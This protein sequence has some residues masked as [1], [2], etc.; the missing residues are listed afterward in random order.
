M[1]ELTKQDLYD[2]LYGCTILGTGGGGELKNG[3]RLIDKAFEDGKKF[4]LADL[5]ELEDE[6]LIATPYMCGAI[7]PI[8]EEEE[9]KYSEL[10]QIG[11]EPAVHAFIAMEEY[12]GEKFHGVVSTELGGS[13]T[14]VAFYTAAMLGKYI[15][16]ADPAGR[17]VPEL[18]HSTYYI[19]NLPIHP[20]AVANEFGD[21]A[22][23][24]K[25]VNDFRAEALV[26]SLAVVSKNS[27]G[28]VDHPAKAADLKNAV[29][30]KAISYALK[31]GK[32]H[33]MA[34]ENNEDPA[35][36]VAEVGEG[37]VRFRGCVKEFDWKTEEGFTIGNIVIEGTG[38]NEGDQYKIWYKN[39]NIIS[40]FNNE[41]DITV[42]DL[43]CIF[44]EETKEPVTNPYF[45]KDMNV[46]VTILPAPKQWKTER[47]LE[48]FGPKSFGYDVEYNPIENRFK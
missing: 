24:T 30:P 42:P 7:S 10:P 5:D 20:I 34:K 46:A 2:I 44:N 15:V 8:T 9:K 17:S 35:Q 48:I 37:I 6:A 4:I 29:I 43:M 22:I 38:N 19:N 32:A 14:A 13:N 27:I 25:V 47:G 28:V 21:A 12:M 26:R 40:W 36:K 31:I 41:I 3:L 33:R 23:F 11:E 45:E 18:Q 16:D 39:E 1:K